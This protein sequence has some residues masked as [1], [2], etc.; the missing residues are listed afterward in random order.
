MRR[1][2]GARK[3]LQAHGMVRGGCGRKDRSRASS[4]KAQ[5]KGSDRESGFGIVNKVKVDMD[6]RV[7]WCEGSLWENCS[8][9]RNDR[10]VGERGFEG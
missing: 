10:A 6:R 8:G 1:Q 3:Q 5:M 2:W 4:L 7:H 9:R